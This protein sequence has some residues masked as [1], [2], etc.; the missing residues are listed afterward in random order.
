MAKKK[1]ART[2]K[3][4]Q[5]KLMDI[6]A[7]RVLKHAFLPSIFFPFGD[8]DAQEEI[9]ALLP[10]KR[11]TPPNYKQLGLAVKKMLSDAGFVD[12]PVQSIHIQKPRNK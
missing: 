11:Q 4:T 9:L 12:D 5:A 8:L 2:T 1:T 10:R 3:R 6:Y 7:R